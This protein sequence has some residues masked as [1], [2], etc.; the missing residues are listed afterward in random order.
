MATY[1]VGDIHGCLDEWL[2]LRDRIERQDSKA[3][4]ILVGDII[5]RGP[6]VVDMVK[7]AMQHVHN[8]GGKYRMVMGNHEMEKIEWL[9]DKKKWG[10][11][12]PEAL[13]EQYDRYG[14]TYEFRV[15]KEPELFVKSIDWFEELPYYKDLRIEDKRI[16]V[17]HGGLPKSTLNKTHTAIKD[18]LTYKDKTNIVWER[19]VTDF[20]DIPNTY[21]IHG[22]SPTVLG[23]A[24]PYDIVD[25]AQSG[26]IVRTKHKF[27]VDCGLVYKK[28]YKDGNL[29]ALRLEDF[30][31]FYLYETVRKG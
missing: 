29:A 11:T 31:E 16:I 27:N 23:C 14:Y 22:H 5:D 7:W 6:Q 21:L 18:N 19:P 4:F 28:Y 15:A 12:D 3:R 25:E 8:K 30:E 13:L 17:V 2:K 9:Y 1:V 20:T 24:F 26:L 10:I